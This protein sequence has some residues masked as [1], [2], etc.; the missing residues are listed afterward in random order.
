MRFGGGIDIVSMD[1]P[2]FIRFGGHRAYSLITT[3]DS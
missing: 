1:P 3:P 2:I